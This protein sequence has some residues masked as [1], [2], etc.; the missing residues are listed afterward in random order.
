[1]LANDNLQLEPSHRGTRR[2]GWV[3][4]KWRTGRTD[5]EPPGARQSGRSW[6]SRRRGRICQWW[7]DLPC[8][9]KP[10]LDGI[11]FPNEFGDRRCR[12]AGRLRRAR[13]GGDCRNH[14]NF[15]RQRFV[16]WFDRP[17]LDCSDKVDREAAAGL[18]V[19]VAQPAEEAFLSR[20]ERSRSGT[21]RLRVTTRS[22]VLGGVGGRGGT[23][24]FGGTAS[25]LPIG[26][27]AGNG[28]TG[29]TGGSGYG[30]GINVSMGTVVL[31]ADT[32][33]GNAAQGGQGGTGGLGG[34]GPIALVFGGSGIITGSGGGG[35]GSG[36][37]SGGGGT[38]LN[39]AGA[40]GNG[41][42]GASGVGR[43]LCTSRADLSR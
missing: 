27:V 35:S 36:S 12:R 26:S 9:W 1:M 32:F 21:P 16:P 11:H 18:A 24:G 2:R 37:G 13:Y 23:A 22:A 14:R 5:P 25:G 28:G 6:G 30:G 19:K 41:G 10:Q 34:S 8:R 29:G 39:S 4:W 15:W 43:R 3:R 40:G 20:A 38:A 31:L 42:N 7:L 17:V 33:N